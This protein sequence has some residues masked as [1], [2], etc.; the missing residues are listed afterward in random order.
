MATPQLGLSVLIPNTGVTVPASQHCWE[1]L[2]WEEGLH[3]GRAYEMVLS[4]RRGTVILGSWGGGGALECQPAGG[5]PTVACACT[6]SQALAVTH[7]G[8][9]V[10]SRISPSRVLVLSPT[11]RSYLASDSTV[12]NTGK[13]GI[14]QDVGTTAP[15]PRPVPVG[16]GFAGTK[17][18]WRRQR[19]TGGC[20]GG[21]LR[22]TLRPS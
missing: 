14:E 16:R 5:P 22:H 15:G 7:P 19:A 20:G 4:S 3:P 2:P 12:L 21:R 9:R 6:R 10:F 17:G 13:H 11:R 18:A 1:S 8:H